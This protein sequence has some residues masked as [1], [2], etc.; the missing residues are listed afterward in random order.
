MTKPT[1]ELTFSRE[2]LPLTVQAWYRAENKLFFKNIKYKDKE[3][4][5]YMFFV[6]DRGMA[7]NYLDMTRIQKIYNFALNNVLER[8]NY[9]KNI[10]ESFYH[11]LKLIQPYL[12]R[13]KE[14]K[15]KKEFIDF[16]NNVAETWAPQTICYWFSYYEDSRMPKTIFKKSEKIRLAIENIIED[17]DRVLS[18]GLINIF[19]KKYQNNY[20]YLSIEEIQSNNIPDSQYLNKRFQFFI[21]QNN[22]KSTPSLKEFIN[23]EK[24]EINK[25]TETINEEIKGQTAYRGKAR[26]K[27]KVCI[28][29]EDIVKMTKGEILVS[30]MTT[31]HFL[32]AIKLAKAFITDEGG[33][34][35]HAAIV[36]RELK[37]PC[38]IGTKI[39]TEVLN[40]GDLV[41]VNA[42]KGI[43]KI[44]KKRHK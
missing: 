29:K 41:E 32:P 42:D 23:K 15:T 30:V 40:N 9:F 6:Y 8:E 1:Y 18:Q 36:A 4:L 10:E 14:I 3:F 26:G 37:K 38:I 5:N 43:V 39:A 31:P 21:Y 44:L 16:F 12:S 34:T 35:C 28:R 25:A 17:C 7:K 2:C 33:I 19:K 13:K 20:Q 11:H 24:I 22:I 27:V